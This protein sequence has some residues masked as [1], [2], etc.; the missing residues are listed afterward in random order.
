MSRDLV[1]GVDLGGTKILT[2]LAGMEGD[3]L[4]RV[5]VPTGAELGQ[6][7][8]IDK[9][10]ETVQAA[11]L[12]AGAPAGSVK[13]VGMGVPGPVDADN[14]FIHFAPNLGWRDV[15]LG[16]IMRRRLDLP[17]YMDNDANLAALGEHRYGAGRGAADMV[18]ITVSTGVGG[19]LILGGRVYRGAG[20]GAGEIGH[21]TV[22]EDG[23]VCRC[24]NRGCL[25]AV[26]S[27]TA[28]A[29]RAAALV[30]EGRGAGILAAAGGDKNKISARA[31]ARAARAGDA[32]A[33]AILRDAGR[34]LGIAV[35][36]LVNLLNPAAVVLGGGVMESAGL[37]WEPML[38]R[39][40]RRS[41]PS[42]LEAVRIVRAALGGE[43][44]A[45]GAVA[46]AIERAS[47]VKA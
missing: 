17:V 18:Y 20:G 31:V 22:A 14:G 45:M 38:E 28:M 37:F 12:E 36:G 9:I 29:R 13:A 39:V 23:P 7:H 24:G 32:A 16:E 21:V 26:A 19:G 44:G 47:P 5:K 43:S 41:L 46:L 4:A 25:E 15:P 11:L 2:V 34:Y 10:V 42:S 6:E 3:V 27:G 40:Q 1:V 30:D 8:V 33:L 35:A